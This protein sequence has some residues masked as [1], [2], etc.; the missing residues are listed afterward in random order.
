MLF[1]L[2]YGATALLAEHSDDAAPG[3]ATAALQGLA[4]TT[5]EGSTVSA[6]VTELQALQAGLDPR[7]QTAANGPLLVTNPTHL[8]DGLGQPLP[9]R[10]QMALCRCGASQLKPSATAATP[11]SGSGRQGPD[12]AADRRDNY[13]GVQVTVHDNAASASTPATA[14]IACRRSSISAQSRSSPP[15]GDGWTRSSGP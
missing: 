8:D 7:I 4:V 14:L 3:E 13:V 15:V 10:P 5:A 6:R 12:R 9:T 1:E 2:A 11:R